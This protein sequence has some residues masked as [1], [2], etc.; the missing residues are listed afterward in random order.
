G[1]LP[2]GSLRLKD[3]ALDAGYVPLATPQSQRL[4]LRNTGTRAAAFRVLPNAK[5]KVTPEKC[6]VA[7]E[8]TVD[9]EVNFSCPD[10]GPL[11]TT[12]ELQAAKLPFVLT[13]TTPVPAKL[14]VDLVS[15]PSLQLLLAKDAWSS[16]EYDQCPLM[17]IGVQGQVVSGSA[18][19]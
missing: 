12:I 9:L 7:P 2:E 13:N 1:Q 11:T 16:T 14:V 15:T 3:K 10:P 6:K 17:R 19:A 8:E 18:R 5:V 4:Q